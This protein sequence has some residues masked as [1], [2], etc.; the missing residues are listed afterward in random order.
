MLYFVIMDNSQVSRLSTLLEKT[1]IKKEQ[2]KKDLISSELRIEEFEI[3]KN[4]VA[5]E[6][7][8]ISK[9]KSLKLRFYINK[10]KYISKIN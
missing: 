6:R 9:G 4:I 10:N 2:E 5:K 1:L 7:I 8:G 3:P